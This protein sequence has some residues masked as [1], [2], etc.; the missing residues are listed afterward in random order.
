MKSVRKAILGLFMLLGISACAT[1]DTETRID[2]VRELTRSSVPYEV[3]WAQTNEV[4]E[5]NC[6]KALELAQ[7]GI[8]RKDAVAIALL[9]NRALQSDLSLL[10][11]A[12][13][14]LTQAGLP[15]N[16]V[17]SLEI[18]F[19]IRN[20]DSA[21]GLF[22]WLSDLWQLPRRKRMAE[23]AARQTDY[24]AALRVLE[25]VVAASDTWDA[26]LNNRQ[27]V[28][29]AEALLEVRRQQAERIL[30]RFNHGLSGT[31]QVQ[32]A[33]AS[34]FEQLTALYRRQQLLVKSETRLSQL[35]ALDDA[36]A[37]VPMI[38]LG[39]VPSDEQSL[40]ETVKMA[41]D[42][43]LDLALAQME[44]ERMASGLNL[45]EALVWGS[46]MVGVSWQ[47]DFKRASGDDNSIGPALAVELPIFD[48]NQAGIAAAGH[49]ML[50]ATR[51]L[52]ARIQRAMKEVVDAY[53]LVVKTRSTLKTLEEELNHAS[54]ERL[55]YT[56]KWNRKMQL[57]F[58]EVLAANAAQLQVE[59]QIME[60]RLFV[61]ESQRGLH[62]ATW[63][64]NTM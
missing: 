2:A 49:K 39:V 29:L 30:I 32:D 17:L 5:Q 59:S 23:I 46:V 64:G 55:A 28:K 21:A 60:T 36:A 11:V 51:A 33:V 31:I 48:Q 10:G 42:N 56:Q 45:E 27:Q 15:S 13:A 35:L 54:S 3:Q 47:G 26:V 4:M 24:R 8:T 57:P 14:N 37:K 16:P 20:A 62:L 7:D 41:L 1:V 43:R 19:P 22:G 58:M 38:P 25:V 53:E 40:R 18:L 9:N 12:A 50:G 6:Q 44:V 61:N 52:E 34:E 63:G